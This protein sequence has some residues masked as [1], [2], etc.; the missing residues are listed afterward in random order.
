MKEKRKTNVCER[1]GMKRE[2]KWR[3]RKPMN[4]NLIRKPR[5]TSL[6]M[7]V[8]CVHL[9]WRQVPMNLEQ[10]LVAATTWWRARRLPTADRCGHLMACPKAAYSNSI[11]RQILA[12]DFGL[13]LLCSLRAALYPGRGYVRQTPIRR[14]HGG[15]PPGSPWAGMKPD[16]LEII[17]RTD[18]NATRH[19]AT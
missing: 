7:Y 11:I 5:R 15:H 6:K 18:V 3:G 16:T 12:R 8:L 4:P 19:T 1:E 2:T 14:V 9:R 13:S 10:A 17:M